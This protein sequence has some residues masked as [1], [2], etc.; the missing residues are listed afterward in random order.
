MY[1]G[2]LR[3]NNELL[4]VDAGKRSGEGLLGLAERRQHDLIEQSGA[5]EANF[6]LGAAGRVQNVHRRDAPA[7]ARQCVT[8]ARAAHT[9][10]IP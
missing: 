1:V 2:T 7:F 8:P 10:R 9:F 3:R 5:H 4:K 6:L